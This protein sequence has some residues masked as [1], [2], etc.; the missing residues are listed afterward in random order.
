MDSSRDLVVA[1]LK[2]G[3]GALRLAQEKLQPSF[4]SGDGLLA[5]EYVCDYVK[6]YNDLPTM[7]LV[8]TKT[9]IPLDLSAPL[10]TL[11]FCID[12][13]VKGY[14]QGALK[15]SLSSTMK[16]L[17]GFQPR[18][19]LTLLE[20][21]VKQLR[22]TQLTGSKIVTL[23]SLGQE[24]IDRYLLVESGSRGIL[25]PWDLMNDVT[26][27]L[28]PK[29][30][31]L[32]VARV[33]IGKCVDEDTLLTDPETGVQRT[34]REVVEGPTAL[35][36]TW[37]KERGIHV[38]PITAKVDTG[39]KECLKVT[40]SSGR[41]VIVTP[42]HPFLTPEGWRRADETSV[43][44]TLGL[45]SHIPFPTRPQPLPPEEVDVLALLLAEGSYTGHH[46]GFSTADTLCLEVASAAAL[47]LET[48]VKYRSGYDYDF[49]PEM[50]VRAIL[51]RHGIDRTKA[52]NKSIPSAVYRLPAPLLSRFLGLFWM[53]DGYVD[54]TGPSICLASR[55]MV[56][57]LQHLLLRFGIQSRVAYKPASCDGK[58]FDSWRLRVYAESYERFAG[59]IPLWGEK[60]E[61]LQVFVEK[62]RNSNVG[63]PKVSDA[64]VDRVYEI[65]SARAGRWRGAGLSEVGRRLGWSSWFSTRNLFGKDNSLLLGNF[66]VFCEVYDCV[67]EFRWLWDSNL[68]WD[69]VDTIEAVGERKIYDLTVAST[70]CFV[71]NDIVVHNTWTAAMLA[72]H[73]WMNN[74][75]VLFATTEMGP[76]R[77]AQRIYALHLKLNYTH[78]THGKLGEFIKK[79]FI[80]GVK[81]LQHDDRFHVV[82]GDFDFKVEN[83]EA[84]IDQVQPDLVLLDGA[85][86]LRVQGNNRIE[87]AANAFDELK[88][89]CNR[90]SV[91]IAVTMQFNREVKANQADT[92]KTESIALT[93]VA[94]WNADLIYGL[95][96]TEDMKAE[97]RLIFK[98]LK[99]R[100]G[101]GIDFECNWNLDT[102]D[103]TQIGPWKKEGAPGG[104]DADEHGVGHGSTFTSGGTNKPLDNLP[105]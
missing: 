36:H 30:L 48:T 19:A 69:S 6:T 60:A 23:G 33:G 72:L 84:A 13:V 14:L 10:G 8:Q 40:F 77:I 12:E 24:V 101:L 93:D 15:K 80:E 90:T 79:N 67:D 74:K 39:R 75:R 7:E 65:A 66:R 85:Y 57:Q 47:L 104:G 99:A 17:D 46:V 61:R 25:A 88:R 5:Y 78:L 9:G 35:V 2:G 91:P 11:E 20:N 27:G 32:F 52:V 31:A 16:L 97:K 98:S 28:W 63:F 83:F 49:I 37:S 89:I 95:I 102:M 43:G 1:V 18:E 56:F 87:R 58:S 29:D 42:E 38:A 103:F 105:F 21:E 68:F 59:A 71:A 70:S 82:G 81:A 34:I 94:S 86:L 53:C 62:S 92:V 4:L 64:F 51:R 96:Q 45:P 54:G 44:Y 22:A 50:P 76:G 26:L 3:K 73:A 41:S 55:T 100:E